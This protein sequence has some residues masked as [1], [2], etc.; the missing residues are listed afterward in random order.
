M[1][2]TNIILA[3]LLTGCSLVAI[4]WTV[5]TRRSF[6]LNQKVAADLDAIIA[7]TLEAVQASKK[8]A[9][10][11]LKGDA[12]PLTAEG[13]D[14]QSPEMLATLV[15]VLVNRYGDIRLSMKDFMISDE[16][17]VSVYV[18]TTSQEIVLSMNSELSLE[19]SY[20]IVNYGNNDD[21]TFH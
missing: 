15:T 7:D 2:A 16:A 4:F 14:M 18:D 8:F 1:I 6:H 13:F 20:S 21:N 10:P 3:L 11:G 5:R 12:G 17:Y 9:S 19:D